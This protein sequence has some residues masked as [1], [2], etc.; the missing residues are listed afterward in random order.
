VIENVPMIH[1]PHCH[2]TYLTAKIMHE[3]DAV[4][5]N[6]KAAVSRQVKVAHLEMTE[7]E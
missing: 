3:I 5:R 7:I 6:R 4:R 2:E 1:C